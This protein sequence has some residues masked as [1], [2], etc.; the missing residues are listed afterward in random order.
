[1]GI[2][3]RRQKL[4]GRSYFLYNQIP[5]PFTIRPRYGLIP[6]ILALL[7]VGKVVLEVLL[8]EGAFLDNTYVVNTYYVLTYPYFIAVTFVMYGIWRPKKNN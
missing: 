8:A 2:R 3:S 4:R 7:G 5:G 6:A 1:M